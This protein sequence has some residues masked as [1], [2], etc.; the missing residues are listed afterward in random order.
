MKSGEVTEEYAVTPLEKFYT[1]DPGWY[2][3][4][5]DIHAVRERVK[6]SKERSSDALH[7]RITLGP[8]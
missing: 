3:R 7:L 4:I 8:N 1:E 5:G 6:I 2:G